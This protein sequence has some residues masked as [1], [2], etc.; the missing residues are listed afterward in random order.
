M[1]YPLDEKKEEDKSGGE[2]MER[3]DTSTCGEVMGIEIIVRGAPKEIA[4]LVTALQG[5]RA[6]LHGYFTKFD[7]SSEP[8]GA[9]LL[10]YACVQGQKLC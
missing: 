5:Q 3:N 9:D 4:A 2:L 10:A 6:E 1:K 7:K 8:L